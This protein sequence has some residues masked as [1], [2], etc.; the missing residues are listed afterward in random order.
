MDLRKAAIILF[1]IPLIPTLANAEKLICTPKSTYTC[2]IDPSNK[3][4]R[5]SDVSRDKEGITML[6]FDT[7][8]F[9]M[10]ERQQ[11][12]D[13]VVSF[14]NKYIMDD[15]PSLYS[16]GSLIEDNHPVFNNFYNGSSIFKLSKF[17][18]FVLARNTPYHVDGGSMTIHASLFGGCQKL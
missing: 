18:N 10:E 12:A 2:I 9:V 17:N 4:Q 8:T 3:K 13:K 11:Q 16:D 7:D 6:V 5:C 14:E 15:K 1:C